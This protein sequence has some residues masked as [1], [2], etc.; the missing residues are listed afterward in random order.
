MDILTTTVEVFSE[1]QAIIANIKSLATGFQ[2]IEFCHTPRE[3]NDVTHILAR[4]GKHVDDTNVVV[5]RP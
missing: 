1:Q 3:A 5:F 2:T 4:C